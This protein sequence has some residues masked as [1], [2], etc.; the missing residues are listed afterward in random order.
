MNWF[1]ATLLPKVVSSQPNRKK[2][3]SLVYRT[4]VDPILAL[5]KISSLQG[6]QSTRASIFIGSS[7]SFSSMCLSIFASRLR[8]EASR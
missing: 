8:V 5:R 4:L 1:G 7:C 2:L 3:R 6:S